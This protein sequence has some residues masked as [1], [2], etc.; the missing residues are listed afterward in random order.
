VDFRFRACWCFSWS[1]RSLLLRGKAFKGFAEAVPE[2]WSAAEQASEK[3]WDTINELKH[4]T[5]NN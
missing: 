4:M 1:R 2:L 3:A 5:S